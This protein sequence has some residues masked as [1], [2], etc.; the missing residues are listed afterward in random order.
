MVV[1]KKNGELIICMDFMKL[2]KASKKD[3]CRLPFF[4]EI[5][6]T[7]VGFIFRWI[8]NIPSDFYSP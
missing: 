6:N 4:D 5:L 7:V 1:P 8:L 2:N 3:P